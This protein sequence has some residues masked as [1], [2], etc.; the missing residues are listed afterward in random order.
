M[1]TKFLFTATPAA[2]LAATLALTGCASD[3]QAASTGA[4]D[5]NA[6]ASLSA[7]DDHALMCPSCETVW[8]LDR[9]GRNPR[10]RRWVSRREMSCPTCD[11][12][13]AAYMDEGE[14]VLHECSECRVTPTIVTPKPDRRRPM[15]PRLR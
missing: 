14:K 11:N 10:I 13:A 1:L 15:N 6:E 9:A 4:T 7:G 12:M 8:T 3:Q 2:A 5:A